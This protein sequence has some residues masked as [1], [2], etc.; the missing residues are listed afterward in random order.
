[1]K[2]VRKIIIFEKSLEKTFKIYYNIGVKNRKNE[3]LNSFP[4]KID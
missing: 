1:M 2:M 4:F 3:F